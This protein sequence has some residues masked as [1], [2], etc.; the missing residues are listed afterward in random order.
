M[1][2]PGV[3]FPNKKCFNSLFRSYLKK[4]RFLLITVCLFS[5]LHAQSVTDSSQNEVQPTDLTDVIKHLFNKTVDTL[6][7]KKSIAILPA[8]GYNPSMGFFIGAKASAGI[9]KGDPANTSLSIIGL[10]AVYSS[11]GIVTLQAR[12]NIFTTHNKW[13]LQGHWQLSKYGMIDYG[14]GT[15]NRNFKGAGFIINDFSIKN[16]DSSFPI[17]YNYVRFTEKIYRKIGPHLYAGGGLSFE[18]F[19]KIEDQKVTNTFATPHFRYSARHGFNPKKYAANGFIL[20]LQYNTREHPIRSYGGIYADLSFRFNRELIGSS[21]NAAQLQYD[22]RKYWSLSKRNPEHVLAL[23]HWASYKLAGAIPYQALPFT[24]S[25][26]YNRS[27]RG[28]TVGRFKGPNYACFETEYRFP[29]TRNKLISGVCFFSMQ[30][31]SDDRDKQVF[32]AWDPGGGAG[33]RILFQ[34]DSRTAI[35]IDFGKGRYGSSGLFFGLNEIF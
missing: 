31:A 35:C 11:K 3:S 30:T 4:G 5:K 10:E 23:W 12:H 20:N 24:G 8:I 7:T 29:I 21:T 9:Q 13:N 6:K 2:R 14:L 25:D 15:G 34:K 32:E 17:K 28:Y 1:N 19:A 33:L 16:G 27:G 22:F 26:T 18:I